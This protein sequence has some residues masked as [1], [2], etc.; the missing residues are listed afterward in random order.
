MLILLVPITTYRHFS[1]CAGGELFGN[2]NNN[3]IPSKFIWLM[4]RGI[5]GSASMCLANAAV[6]ILPV[7]DA[8]A[9]MQ[10]TVVWATLVSWIWLKDKP[11]WTD[12]ASI[13][14]TLIG[15][16]IFAKPSFI[17]PT[18]T[19][20]SSNTVIGL[21]YAS[22]CAVL[23]ACGDVIV[24]KLGPNVHF[25]VSI[26]YFSIWGLIF[27]TLLNLHT[28]G[29]KSPCSYDLILLLYSGPNFLIGRV[30]I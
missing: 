16:I 4:L 11:H 14:V 21:S 1:K 7:G 29:I 10:A 28:V 30:T 24:R 9:V 8:Y 26:L 18:N 6:A 20:T 3:N 25:T 19:T 22:G 13:P 15:V 27:S 5:L 17:F 23:G 2:I 12:F